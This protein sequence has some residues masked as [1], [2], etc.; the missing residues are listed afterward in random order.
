MRQQTRSLGE[1]AI[2]GGA[3][4]QMDVRGLVRGEQLVDVALPI[5]HDGDEIGGLERG[6]ALPSEIYPAPR[7]LVRQIALAPSR[8]DLAPAPPH[9]AASQPDDAAV[10]GVDSQRGMHEKAEIAAVACGAE[11]LYAAGMGLIVDLARVLDR[12]HMAA[13]DPLGAIAGSRRQHLS[14]RHVPRVEK[15]LQPHL[16]SMS[17]AQSL[18]TNRAPGTQTPQQ[19]SAPFWRRQSPKYPRSVNCPVMPTSAN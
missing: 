16:S 19:I 17:F 2:L 15:T 3:H 12:Q 7:F 10:P 4:Q 1:A 18:E 8:F 11:P 5:A 9:D 13:G 14:R 6:R